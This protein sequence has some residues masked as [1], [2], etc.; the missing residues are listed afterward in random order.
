MVI[1]LR[2]KAKEHGHLGAMILT[3]LIILSGV[4]LN[5]SLGVHA[6]ESPPSPDSIIVLVD[7]SFKL[8]NTYE[9]ALDKNFTVHI[10]MPGAS[11]NSTNKYI[12]RVDNNYTNGSFFNHAQETFLVNNTK[13]IEVLEVI[14]NNETRLLATSI[15]ILTGITQSQIDAGTSPF[16]IN[17]LPSEW[18]SKEWGIFWSIIVSAIICSF[19]SYRMVLRYRRA[20]GV[21]EVR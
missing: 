9:K 2:M 19:I 21:Q 15:R 6:Q 10:W 16:T 17:L 4:G 7:S 8:W 11:N 18:K 13:R 12:I 14:V 5:C 3:A 20:R 1:Y